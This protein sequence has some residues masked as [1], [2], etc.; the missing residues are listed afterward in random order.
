VLYSPNEDVSLKYL[1]NVNGCMK[2]TEGWNKMR[3]ETGG[4]EMGEERIVGMF[5]VIYIRSSNVISLGKKLYIL[6]MQL[7]K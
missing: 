5:W 4:E 6:R 7:Y 2:D 3:S 1:K